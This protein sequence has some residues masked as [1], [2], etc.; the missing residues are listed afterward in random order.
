MAVNDR[1]TNRDRTRSSEYGCAERWQV[2]W[3]DEQGRQRKKSFGRKLDAQ[4]YDAEVRKALKDGTYTDPGA[5]DITLQA[6]AEAWRARQTH[7]TASAERV[8]GNLRRHVYSAPGTPGR[9]PTGAPS[10][11]DYPLRI[12]A[13]QPSIVQGWLAA[14]P[15]HPNSVRMVAAT[16]TPVFTA[17]AED[18]L[19]AR[20][21]MKASQVKLPKAVKTDVSAWS[22]EQVAAVAAELPARWSALAVLGAAVGMRQGELFALAVDDVDFL[23]RTVFRAHQE[24]EDP[25]RAGVGPRDPGPGRACAPVPAV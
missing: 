12:L 13:K 14:I 1:W 24:P 18:G 10:I 21:P 4:N 5:G 20:S 15:L 8:A 7:D 2:R 3:R 25:R 9:T 6:Y 19:I 17:A 11:G 16:V 22:A 23:R